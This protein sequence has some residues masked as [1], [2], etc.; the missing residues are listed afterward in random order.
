MQVAMALAAVTNLL[1][2]PT[3]CLIIH[4]FHFLTNIAVVRTSC[5][6]QLNHWH[7][8]LHTA[9]TRCDP[10][11]RPLTMA[12]HLSNSTCRSQQTACL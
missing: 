3:C 9:R 2:P 11:V 8:H 6:M 7:Y 10:S 1:P 4:T 12:Q 5:G